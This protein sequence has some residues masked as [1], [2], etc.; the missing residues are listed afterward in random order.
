M[1]QTS[2]SWRETL[3]HLSDAAIFQQNG[4]QSMI[5]VPIQLLFLTR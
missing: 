3:P 5:I 1:P 4:G 2:G